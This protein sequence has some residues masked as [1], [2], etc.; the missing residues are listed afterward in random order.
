MP[1]SLKKGPF[2]ADALLTKIEKLNAEGQKKVFP[3]WS[4]SSTIVPIMIG[5]TIGVHNGREHIPVFITDPLVGHKIDL[6][7]LSGHN[8]IIKNN[9]KKDLI[10]SEFF[11]PSGESQI[12]IQDKRK[13][14]FTFMLMENAT[15]LGGW[16]VEM[17]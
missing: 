13:V 15:K 14:K 6:F 16:F 3:T 12:L 7:N 1:R 4:R 10:Y 11:C 5:H 2:V 9:S 8:I 17:Y